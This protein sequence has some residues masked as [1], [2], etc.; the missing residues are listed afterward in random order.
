MNPS[1]MPSCL[2]APLANVGVAAVEAAGPPHLRERLR[3]ARAGELPEGE[4]GALGAELD[5][6]AGLLA[7]RR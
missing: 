6:L 1:A 3:R 5:L 4:A 7:S 2:L